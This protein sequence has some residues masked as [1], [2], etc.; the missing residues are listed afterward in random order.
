M[1]DPKWG[2]LE[3]GQWNGLMRELVSKQTDMVLSAMRVNA[4]REAAVDFTSPY[5]VSP[6]KKVR[7]LNTALIKYYSDFL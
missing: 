5:L 6:S 4:E 7:L 3:N 1:E 2:T